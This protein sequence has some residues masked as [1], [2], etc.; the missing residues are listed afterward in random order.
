MSTQL[1]PQEYTIR[2]GPAGCITES[3]HDMESVVP[4]GYRSIY[5]IP[6]PELRAVPI[7]TVILRFSSTFMERRDTYY[8]HVCS[9]ADRRI[10]VLDE[11][12]KPNGRD[13]VMRDGGRICF[14][15]DREWEP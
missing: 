7:E 10:H 15:S 1:T 4:D 6:S 8:V 3:R 12:S 11:V 13:P 5:E 9:R 14:R 2:G